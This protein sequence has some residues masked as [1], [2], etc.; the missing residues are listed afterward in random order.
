MKAT[1]NIKI[2]PQFQKV[3]LQNLQKAMK[4]TLEETKDHLTTSKTMPRRMGTLEAENFYFTITD[5]TS[6]VGVL[7]NT[8]PY[9]RYLYYGRIRHG[10]GKDTPYTYYGD[11]Q[12]NQAQNPMAKKEWLKPYL[13]GVFLTERF[14]DN[15]K[16]VMDGEL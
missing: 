13:D 1:V 11:I 2:D 3:M 7:S 14:S 9:S 16:K 15:L 8:V 5:G 4:L 10:N 6:V 12:F